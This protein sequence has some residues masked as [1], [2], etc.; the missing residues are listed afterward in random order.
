MSIRIIL[1]DDHPVVRAGLVTMLASEPDVEIVGEASNGEEGLALALERAPDVVL[2]DLRMPKLDG[3]AA[4]AKLRAANPNIRVVLL[5]T[6]DGDADILRAVEAG[7]T[8]YLLKDAPRRELVDAI[9][10]AARGQ[11]VLAPDVASRL[12]GQIRNPAPPTEALSPREVQVLELV[13]SGASNKE[14]GK[15][16][17]VSEATIKT[18]LLHVFAKLGVRDRTSAVTTALEKGI[19]KLGR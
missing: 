6:Y 13:A 12:M 18:H 15:K 11:S 7:A 9:R 2:M 1:V 14:I 4:T 10:A 17:R 16:L 5:T 3:A 8:G 19:L